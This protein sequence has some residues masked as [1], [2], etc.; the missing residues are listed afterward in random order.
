[1]AAREQQQGQKNLVLKNSFFIIAKKHLMTRPFNLFTLLILP[2]FFTACS[3]TDDNSTPAPGC[4]L[5]SLKEVFGG[6]TTAAFYFTYDNQGRVIRV[7]Y[8][9]KNSTNYEIYTYSTDKIVVSGTAL[10]NGT[11]VYELDGSGRVIKYGNATFTYNSD[12]YLVKMVDVNGPHSTTANYIYQNGNLV[13]LDQVGQY[14]LP[15]PVNNV[16]LY[17]YDLSQ[18]SSSAPGDPITFTATHRPGLGKYFGKGSANLVKKE[19]IRMQNQPE[20]TRVHT[21]TRD[22]NGNII[23]VSTATAGGTGQKQLAYSC[24]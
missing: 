13:K 19:I 24:K 8:N 23:L 2:L 3:K 20:E 14:G 15:Q 4:T 9:T 21:Y 10:G 7:D 1:V 12:G 11:A 6:N 18:S 22:A 16:V 17:E 5:E